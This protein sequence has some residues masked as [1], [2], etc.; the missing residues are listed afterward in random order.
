M[1]LITLNPEGRYVFVGD[2]HGDLS[3]STKVIQKYLDTHTKI[4]FLGDYVD[5]G[6]DSRGNV[7]FL[8]HQKEEHPKNI[9]LIKGNHETYHLKKFYPADF[10]ESLS[11][12]EKGKYGR[13]FDPLPLA[14]SIGDIIGVHGA[15]PDITNLEEINSI[16]EGEDNWGALVWGDFINYDKDADGQG[17]WKHTR[18][19]YGRKYFD[20]VMENIGKSVLIRGHDPTAP[21]KLFG[22]HCLTIFTSCAYGE[23]KIAIADF[24]KGPIKTIEDLV[25]RTI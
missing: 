24:D 3:A 20:R 25:I 4:C 17:K 1:N 12:V 22:N 9:F 16:K 18:P 15:L 10:W 7:E 8:W 21:K 19:E 14:I 6:P 5:R 2:T 13:K 23:R 11:E